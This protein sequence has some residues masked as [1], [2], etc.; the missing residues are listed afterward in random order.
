M[1]IDIT[2]F[3]LGGKG[4]AETTLTT[5]SNSLKDKGHIVRIFMAYPPSYTNWLN[6]LDNIYYYGLGATINNG[7]YFEFARNYK[8]ILSLIGKPDICIAFYSCIESYICYYALEENNSL[9]VPLISFLLDFPRNFYSK[10]SLGF[11]LAHFAINKEIELEIKNLLGEK[12]V[13]SI[14]NLVDDSNITLRKNPENTIEL[15]YIGRL[16]Q[17]KNVSYLLNS[18]S[19]LN[20]NFSLKIIGDG[21][22]LNS[23][24]QQAIDLNINDKISWQ[25]WTNDPW[26]NIKTCSI[27]ILPS[28][29]E[30]FSLVLI[31]ALLRGIPVICAHSNIKENYI[32]HGKNGW[33][34][35][36]N[37]EKSLANLL[38]NIINNNVSLP[39]KK[40]CIK[41]VEEFSTKIISSKIEKSLLNEINIFKTTIS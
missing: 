24:K 5:L 41:S 4:G 12:R 20:N 22:L 37:N 39:N 7:S 2:T 27:L 6:T 36:I 21:S 1:I 16:E 18:L 29:E 30:K 33:F 23:L 17:E 3:Y 34:I 14:N 32:V 38:N 31:E 15:L 9:Q 25:K 40:D 35:D 13:Y 26:K 10:E 28:K 19:N 11:S 8:N